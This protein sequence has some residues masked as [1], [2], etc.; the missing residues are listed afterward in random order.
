MSVLLSKIS[1]FFFEQ[2]WMSCS[3]S[4]KIS[5]CSLLIVVSWEDKWHHSECPLLPLSFLPACVAEHDATWYWESLWSAG[6]GCP[7]VPGQHPRG[8]A[9][10]NKITMAVW[11]LLGCHSEPK[12]HVSMTYHWSS[13]SVRMFSSSFSYCTSVAIVDVKRNH[14][15]QD[16]SFFP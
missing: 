3:Y 2:K 14:F 8:V 7:A 9:A 4:G 12:H 13:A 16:L 15:L 5:E 6:V 1:S 11:A 10:T